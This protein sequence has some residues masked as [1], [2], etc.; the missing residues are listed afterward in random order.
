M[1]LISFQVTTGGVDA[2]FRCEPEEV[3]TLGREWFRA[4]IVELRKHAP[5]NNATLCHDA[6]PVDKVQNRRLAPAEVEQ[7]RQAGNL[8]YELH[9]NFTFLGV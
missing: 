4:G 2:F 5:V 8:E 6:Y 7:C 3:E 9:G 1:R